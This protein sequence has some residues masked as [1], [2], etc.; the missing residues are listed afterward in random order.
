MR[1]EIEI[2][3]KGPSG[4]KHKIP[5]WADVAHESDYGAD[6]DGNRGT[7]MDFIEDFGFTGSDIDLR[8]LV[9]DDFEALLAADLEDAVDD[10]IY[11][12]DCDAKYYNY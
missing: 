10:A 1:T 8:E 2:K 4:K 3:W 5:M 12:A 11:S 9:G 6:A 7:P